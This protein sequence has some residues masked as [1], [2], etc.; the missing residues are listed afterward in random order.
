M[1][2]L[3]KENKKNL[4]ALYSGE[5][6]PLDDKICQVKFFHPFC[7]MT[8][9]ATEYDPE[10]GVFFGWVENG[11]FSEWGNFSL[12]EMKDLKVRGLGMERDMYFS[13]KPMKD[14][15][16]YQRNG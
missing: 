10:S 8:W 9:Y 4:P 15:P 7:S 11:Q 5:N 14:I 12:Q 3:T 6:I 13:P 1:M 16:N 2:L